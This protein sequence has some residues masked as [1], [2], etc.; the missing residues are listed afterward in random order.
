MAMLS[1]SACDL[2]NPSSGND[3]V[4]DNG[5]GDGNGDGTGISGDI[6]TATTWSSDTY[7]SGSVSVKSSGSLT[8]AAGVTVTFASDTSLS[9]EE[10]ASL[11]AVG[12]AAKPISFTAVNASTYWRSL[13]LNGTNTTLKYV[14]VSRAGH[15]SYSHPAVYF[16]TNGAIA[17]IE[18][19]TI[20]GNL[21]GGIDATDAGSGTVIA[22]NSFGN[23]GDDGATIYD[24]VV[25]GASVSASGN[26]ALAGTNGYTL[27][28]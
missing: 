27:L 9:V 2:L 20:A 25:S 5:N 16:Y 18:N 26:A 11:S 12:T 3:T 6:T 24:L 28:P 21:S 17:D 22:N 23:N 8:I 1:F 13:Y 4:K 19:C 7:V 15:S 14:T 10:G